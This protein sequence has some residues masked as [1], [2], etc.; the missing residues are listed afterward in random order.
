M[1]WLIGTSFLALGLPGFAQNPDVL[2]LPLAS[3]RAI[4]PGTTA[5]E[6]LSAAEKAQLALRNTFGPRA[7]VNRAMIA[8]LDQWTNDPEEWEQGW[9]AYGKR[10][11]SRMGRIAVRNAIQVAADVAFRTDPRYDRCE[12]SGFGART[13]H[14]WRRVFMSRRNGGGEMISVSRL[15][16]AYLT[17]IITDQ[18]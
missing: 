15:A 4:A 7:L 11:G 1:R 18:W 3:S 17:P 2:P 6:P 8:G 12:C 13:G 10:Y 5:I 9:D 16:G 14:A